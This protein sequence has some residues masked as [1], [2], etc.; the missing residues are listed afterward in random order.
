[1]QQSTWNSYKL[2]ISLLMEMTCRLLF[3]F[4]PSTLVATKVK[5]CFR[6][7]IAKGHSYL[8]V[9]FHFSFSYRLT[10]DISS[11]MYFL[12]GS[13]C[14]LIKRWCLQKV[15]TLFLFLYS[16]FFFCLLLTLF[17]KKCWKMLLC[18]FYYFSSL[19]SSTL[20]C[21]FLVVAFNF[22]YTTQQI[23]SHKNGWTFRKSNCISL[24]DFN[25][26]KI[27]FWPVC[28]DLEIT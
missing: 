3:S 9:S 21:S 27:F 2:Y 13:S 15:R 11:K 22:F 24:Y 10:F 19:Y 7:W 4:K 25:A 17:L 1:M 26:W 5:I 14:R 16:C 23:M 8:F 18:R 12:F 6:L 20:N 28:T